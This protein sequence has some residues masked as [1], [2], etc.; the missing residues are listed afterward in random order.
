MTR[1][2]RRSLYA[3]LGA[4]TLLGIIFSAEKYISAYMDGKSITILESMAYA[5]VS[6]YTFG[7]LAL[8]SLYLFNR[9]PLKREKVFTGIAVYLAASLMFS[10]LHTIITHLLWFRRFGPSFVVSD[11]LPMHLVVHYSFNV[12]IFACVLGAYYLVTYY[13]SFREKEIRASQ[14]E[15]QLSMSRLAV[16]KMQI[17]P[18][19]LFNTLHAI[20]ALMYDS[21]EAAHNMLT[22]LS[23]LLR[24]SLEGTDQQEVTLDEEIHFLSQYLDIQRVRF[25]DRLSISL[26]IRPDTRSALIPSM[27]LQPLVENAI[28]HGVEPHAG[29]AEV[30]IGSLVDNGRLIVQIIDNGPGLTA[31]A[32][33]EAEKGVGL[34]NTR[35]R[36]RHLYGEEGSLS[37]EN[38]PSG[39]LI[40]TLYLPYRTARD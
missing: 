30:K 35:E 21:V 11:E 9:Y 10:F 23:D 39:G 13:R 16:L 38:G 18:H 22:R 36:L 24:I 12:V 40:A 32:E 19:F 29:Q 7:F 15:A 28:K 25:Q 33:I 3:S 5:M 31:S 34:V 2:V 6:W 37:L 20:G 14:L 27:I 8:P 4:S 17:Q 1:D 26:D